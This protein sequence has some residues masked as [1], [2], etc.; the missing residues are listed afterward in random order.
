MRNFPHVTDIVEWRKKNRL[1]PDTKVFI[2][3]GGYGGIKKALYARGWVQN[4]DP[5]SSIFNMKWV[6]QSR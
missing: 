2:V 5:T 1:E 4:P 3:T 6:L